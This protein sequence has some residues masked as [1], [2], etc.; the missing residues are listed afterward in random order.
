M[1]VDEAMGNS[2]PETAPEMAP[3]GAPGGVAKGSMGVASA[4]WRSANEEERAASPSD[5]GAGRLDNLSRARVMASSAVPSDAILSM[6]DFAAA[7]GRPE[8]FTTMQMR[9]LRSAAAKCWR[10]G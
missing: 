4:R 5:G 7:R 1:K 3:D 2:A 8:S 10:N 6:M 9:V